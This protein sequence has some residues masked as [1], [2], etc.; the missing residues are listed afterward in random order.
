MAYDGNLQDKSYDK[1]VFS[2]NSLV[3]L[4]SFP[5]VGLQLNYILSASL[6]TILSFRHQHC[7]S[8]PSLAFH[9]CVLTDHKMGYRKA[10]SGSSII[11]ET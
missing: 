9:N 2:I 5:C 11:E 10:L 4:F 8:R 1:Q 3:V 7:Y 6:N